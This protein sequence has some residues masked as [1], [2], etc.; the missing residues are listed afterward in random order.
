LQ[1]QSERRKT[2]NKFVYYYKPARLA[3][4]GNML[5]VLLTVGGI[6]IPVLLLFLEQMNHQVMSVVALG[7]VLLFAVS[8]ATVTGARP[9]DLMFG[10]AT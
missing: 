10:T 5:V 1:T 3:A 9:L 8:V 2:D 4:I 6:A 7:F